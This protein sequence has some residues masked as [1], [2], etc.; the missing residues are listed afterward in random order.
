MYTCTLYETFRFT[1]GLDGEHGA[2]SAGIEWAPEKYLTTFLEALL[3]V[4][5]CQ[6]HEHDDLLRFSWLSLNR[7]RALLPDLELS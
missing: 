1:C 4:E 3:F 7:A 5:E 2:F 6:R